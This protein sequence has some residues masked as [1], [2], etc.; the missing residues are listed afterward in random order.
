M[1]GVTGIAPVI[2]SVRN[3][4][5]FYYHYTPIQTRKL[6]TNKPTPN[7]NNA[8]WLNAT[9]KVASVNTN[10]DDIINTV[11]NIISIIDWI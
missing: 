11:L 1:V 6:A 3:W 7:G 5:W 8:T 2:L 10:N 4:I 9:P